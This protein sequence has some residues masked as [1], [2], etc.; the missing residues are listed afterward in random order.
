MHR[1]DA[2]ALPA[3][4]RIHHGV[5][6]TLQDTLLFLAFDPREVDGQVRNS[7]ALWEWNPSTGALHKRWSAFDFVDPRVES[8]ARSVPED[9]LHANSVSIGSRGNILVS[10]HYLDQVI[11]LASDFSASE[12]RL[13]G[14]RSTFAVDLPSGQ[15]MRSM[16]LSLPPATASFRRTRS[17]RSP[18]RSSAPPSER[19][20]GRSPRPSHGRCRVSREVS[21]S[22]RRLAGGKRV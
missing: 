17:D 21:S 16:L 19:A 15:R 22:S 20:H 12:W 18:A 7:E 9:W 1:L 13:G 10:L 3:G 6:A 4:Q 11:S 2:S 8:G 5:T 14:A